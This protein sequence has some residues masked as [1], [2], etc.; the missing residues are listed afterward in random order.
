MV[1]ENTEDQANVRVWAAT[2]QHVSVQSPP[3][4]RAHAILSGLW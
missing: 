4:C 2:R 1:S 3:C